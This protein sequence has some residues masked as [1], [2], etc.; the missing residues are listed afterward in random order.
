MGRDFV[1]CFRRK[2]TKIKT[3]LIS[4]SNRDNSES[5]FSVQQFI[6]DNEWY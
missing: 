4:D 3:I 2:L 1:T 6:N 5:L